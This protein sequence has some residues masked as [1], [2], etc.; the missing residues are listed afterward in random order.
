MDRIEQTVAFAL[1]IET[2]DWFQVE[3]M[4]TEDFRYYGITPDPVDKETW[5]AFIQAIK[6]ALPDLT[7]H[8]I[9]L[10]Q[11]ANEVHCVLQ[12]NG[13]HTQPLQLP[14]PHLKPLPPTLT[15]VHL[16]SERIIVKFSD[17]KI[18][19]IHSNHR[20]HTGLIGI[21]EQLGIQS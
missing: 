18:S 13:H 21:L 3:S 9:D 11:M 16:P 8:L 14:L 5:Q 4:T 6:N 15:H 1:A 2:S 19:E 17:D 10:K 7:L 20:M 12:I